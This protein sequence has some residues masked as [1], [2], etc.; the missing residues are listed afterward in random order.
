MKIQN[1]AFALIAGVMCSTAQA[2]IVV[3]DAKGNIEHLQSALLSL[4]AKATLLGFAKNEYDLGMAYY[5]GKLVKRDSQKA[6]EWLF[7]AAQKNHA[8]AMF[9]LGKMM[10]MGDGLQKNVTLGNQLIQ[11]SA[12][13]GYE[14]AL[15]LLNS[16]E[17]TTQESQK[18]KIMQVKNTAI[19]NGMCSYQ[20]FYIQSLG[21]REYAAQQGRTVEDMEEYVKGPCK[22]NVIY[23]P[24]NVVEIAAKLYANNQS[25][26]AYILTK[27]KDSC[28]EGE[29]G[30][31]LDTD[32][33]HLNEYDKIVQYDAKNNE[34]EEEYAEKFLKEKIKPNQS[35]CFQS[36]WAHSGNNFCLNLGG[37]N[38]YQ[39][40][41]AVGY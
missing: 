16:N 4:Q 29:C 18:L 30:I 23:K 37:Q 27:L 19:Y 9:T 31:T 28:D 15:A 2:A 6:T 39:H 14:P 25:Y 7:K 1:I 26:D 34:I 24:N 3:K 21:D 22:I 35:Y 11:T 33:T 32:R 17:K 38:V 40:D 41:R 36:M 5:E 10:L 8:P 13:K 20:D 12:N